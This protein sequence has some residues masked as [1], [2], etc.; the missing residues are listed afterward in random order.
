MPSHGQ[1]R[2]KEASEERHIKRLCVSLDTHLRTELGWPVN[3]QLQ[4]PAPYT[5]PEALEHLRDHIR[6]I[7]RR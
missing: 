4:N 5:K 6:K 3:P 1:K 7:E 2:S